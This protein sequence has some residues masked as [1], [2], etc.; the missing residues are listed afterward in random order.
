MAWKNLW[1][2]KLRQEL[3]R[4]LITVPVNDGDVQD[5]LVLIDR[6]VSGAVTATSTRDTQ[7]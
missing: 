6:M 1:T 7:A 5:Y 4:L 2:C 3:F